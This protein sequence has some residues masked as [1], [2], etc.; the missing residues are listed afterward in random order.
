MLI[1]YWPTDT[2]DDATTG[3]VARVIQNVRSRDP[4]LWALVDARLRFAAREDTELAHFERQGWAERMPYADCALHEFKFPPRRK[5]GVV[6]IYFCCDPITR[7]CVWLLDAEHKTG[8]S[9]KQHRG[10]VET[11]DQRCREIRKEGARR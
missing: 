1:R 9:N 2:P 6:R 5:R 11:A 4:Q 8:S 3:P 7:N 10:V